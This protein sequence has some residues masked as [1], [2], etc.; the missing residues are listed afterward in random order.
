MKLIA[1]EISIGVCSN[2]HTLALDPVEWQLPRL[3]VRSSEHKVHLCTLVPFLAS[4]SV[5]LTIA[6]Q[7]PHNHRFTS[8]NGTILTNW[9]YT[10][11]CF[12]SLILELN[13]AENCNTNV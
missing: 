7:L 12:L 8:G 4:S 2:R 13:M 5:A 6:Q 10:V 9:R 3:V 1:L 11:Q